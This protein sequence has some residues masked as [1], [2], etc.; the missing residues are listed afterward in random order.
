MARHRR[1]QRRASKRPMTPSFAIVC[2]RPAARHRGTSRA[3]P[4]RAARRRARARSASSSQ[5]AAAERRQQQ[6]GAAR[7]ARPAQRA[8]LGGLGGHQPWPQKAGSPASIVTAAAGSSARGGGGG[9]RAARRG[10]RSARDSAAWRCG[11]IRS[12][13][14]AF[15]PRLADQP[16]GVARPSGLARAAARR[17]AS[18]IDQA[19]PAGGPAAGAMI[20]SGRCERDGAALTIPPPRRRRAAP[21]SPASAAARR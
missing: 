7:Q 8:A 4:C 19:A 2:A 11:R 3:P 13:R 20:V 16:R 14:R 9:L 10:Q 18:R 12:A 1:Q 15:L 17:L 21:S 5:R 6:R